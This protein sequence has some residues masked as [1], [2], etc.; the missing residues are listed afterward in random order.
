MLS[1]STSNF[2]SQGP[3]FDC[4]QL[5]LLTSDQKVLDLNTASSIRLALL[6]SDHKV[7]DSNA[8]G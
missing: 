2:R 1:V 5:A 3:G 6:P 8:V 4:C 7:L